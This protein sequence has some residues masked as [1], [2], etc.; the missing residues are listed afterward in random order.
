MYT[1]GMTNQTLLQPLFA[2]LL[3]LLVL[4]LFFLE[5]GLMAQSVGSE[6]DAVQD[7]V[8]SQAERAPTVYVDCS[9]CDYDLMREE[10]QYLNYVRD[11]E[12]ADIHVFVTSVETTGGREYEISFIGRRTFSS[13]SFDLTYRSDR[14]NT[15][16]EI[17][18]GLIR[19]MQAG[20]MPYLN[21]TSIAPWF[22]ISYEGNEENELYFSAL[23]D[24]WDFWVFEAYIGSVRL[25][26]ES[27]DTDFDSRWGIYA[28]RVTEEW[29]LRIRPYFNYS[30]REIRREGEETIR[31]TVERH[32]LDTYALKSLDSHWSA[33]LFAS[34]ITRND[35]NLRHQF[36]LN[37]AI[38]YSLLPYSEA[39]RRAI[40]AT[41]QIGYSYTDYFEET[42]FGKTEESLF[43]QKLQ[44][45]VSIQQPWGDLHG[46][47]EGSHYFHD[48][49]LRRIEFF[50]GTSVRLT[51]GLSLGLNTNFQMINDQITLPAGDASLEDIL[52]RQRQLA[53]DYSF[54]ASVSI[55]YTFGSDFANIVNTR[56]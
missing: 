18:M 20:F 24:P 31:R 36:E 11:P 51:E 7:T 12:Q 16:D 6:A 41:Y 52:L 5:R 48:A 19:T 25:D 8:D 26:L 39:T 27:N 15:S 44:V 43:N 46:G 49:T 35:Y 28:D 3:F 9:P 4:S 30:L 22:D 21:Q 17:R 10:I 50:T 47:V 32:G 14:N 34:Y 56:F 42:I 33:G 1:T 38:E 37:P 54:S 2:R 13:I 55:T 23:D 53:T 40:T 29:K 45:A